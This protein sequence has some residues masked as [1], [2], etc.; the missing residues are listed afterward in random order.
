MAK[1]RKPH[2]HR[3]PPVGARTISGYRPQSAASE[4]DDDPEL[5]RNVRRALRADEPLEILALVSSL[6]VAIE[7]DRRRRPRGPTP[8][9]LN[10][11]VESFIDIERR[12]TGALLTALAALIDDELL[13]RRIRHALAARRLDIP[14]WL[15]ALGQPTVTRV[16]EMTDVLGDASNVVLELEITARHRLSIIVLIDHNLG[17]LVKDAFVVPDPIAA[18]IGYYERSVTGPEHDDI[19]FADLDAAVA[20]ARIAEG[21]ELA[22]ITVPPF[23]SDTWPACRPIVEWALRQL[24]AGGT[25]FDRPEWSDTDRDALAKR[26]FASAFGAPFDDDEHRSLLE[27]LLWFAIDYGPRD[28]LRWSPTSVERLLADWLPRKVVAP[29]A[30][31]AKAPDL[32]RAFIRFAHA[33]RAVRPALTNETLHAVDRW[34][35]DYQRVIRSPRPQGPAALLARMAELEADGV[36]GEP[37]ALDDAND[38]DDLDDDDFELDLDDD[39]IITTVHENAVGGADAL[40]RLDAEPLPDEP[41]AWNRIGDADE[42]R[43]RV[44]RVLELCDDA[45]DALFDVEHRTACRRLLA[46]IAATAPDALQRGN[47]DRTAAALCWT[48]AKA[49]RTL[50]QQKGD[51]TSKQLHEHLGIR[52][53]DASQRATTLLK[54]AGFTQAGAYDLVLGSPDYL[55]STRRAAIVRQRDQGW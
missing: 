44:T 10:E 21:I 54:A 11:L 4:R 33:E 29:A 26:F 27:S 17:D 50:S 18:T 36:F 23:E 40:A 8:P 25:S 5:M 34:E 2:G 28:P 1:K 42:L 20:R 3:R 15:A 30:Y 46:R 32:L 12:E 35:R 45:C 37:A 53:G 24:P 13:V 19:A 41:F 22:R 51:V 7:P 6:L 9:T 38:D 52:G 55:V 31:L 16:V 47:A 43:A 14:M 48:I 39:L 49:N